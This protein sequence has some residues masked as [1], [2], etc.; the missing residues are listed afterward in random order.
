[1]SIPLPQ[2]MVSSEDH[3]ESQLSCETLAEVKGDRPRSKWLKFGLRLGCTLILLAFLFKSFSWTSVLQKLAHLDDGEILIGVVIGLVGVILSSYQWH[4]LLEGEGIH[5]DLRRLINLYFVGIAFNHFLPT[6]MGG[7]VVK[8]YYVGKEAQNPHGSVSAV[9]MSRVTGFLGMLMVSLPALLIWHN[10]FASWI[11][12]TFTL[13]C[14]AMCT[15]LACVYFAVTLLPRLLKGKWIKYRAISTA[16][17]VGITMRESLKHPRALLG[18]LT[19]GICFHITATL[20][21][22]AVAYMLHLHIPLPFFFVAIPLVSLIAFLPTTI[23]GYGLR[24]NAFIGIFST[25][26]VDAATATALVL[27]MDA[28]GILFG[29]IGGIIYLFMHEKKILNKPTEQP[30]QTYTR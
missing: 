2:K 14:L 5:I 7:D 21:Y 23:N 12:I 22:Y 9:V 15:A 8:A 10:L 24:E 18:S 3:P 27:L 17:D 19:F 1:M 11:I 13:A 30:A 6:G 25:L 29:L 16:L 28:Q 26:H 20:N 4:S